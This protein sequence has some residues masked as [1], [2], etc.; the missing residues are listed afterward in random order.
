MNKF[1]KMFAACSSAVC[2]VT[3]IPANNYVATASENSVSKDDESYIYRN[4]FRYYAGNVYENS[5]GEYAVSTVARK[6]GHITVTIQGVNGQQVY[7]NEFCNISFDDSIISD[8]GSVGYA[9]MST[10][11][12]QHIGIS[13]IKQYEDNT[14]TYAVF[15]NDYSEFLIGEDLITF[16]FYVNSEYMDSEISFCVADKTITL[17]YGEANQIEFNPQISRLKNE[18]MY[19]IEENERLQEQLNRSEMLFGDIDMDG[20]ID[21]KDAQKLLQYYVKKLAGYTGT[22]KMYIDKAN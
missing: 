20:S 12:E 21:A 17:P 18:L 19:Q 1:I 16:D 7:A 14:I 4:T 3:A 6:N 22:L 15:Y 2:L 11:F 9:G 13:H 8:I 5:H 10:C